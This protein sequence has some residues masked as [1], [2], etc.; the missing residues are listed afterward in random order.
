MTV[1][2][3]HWISHDSWPSWPFG[4]LPSARLYRVASL[5]TVIK[6][7]WSTAKGQLQWQGS[8]KR[9]PSTLKS[10]RGGHIIPANLETQDQAISRGQILG[11]STE[12]IGFQEAT[13]LTLNKHIS[14][15]MSCEHG[16]MPGLADG[17][18][19]QMETVTWFNYSKSLQIPCFP[20]SAPRCRQCNFGAVHL[21]FLAST[22][23]GEKHVSFEE[24]KQLIQFMYSCWSL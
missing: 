6:E 5:D 9:S 18:M 20:N 16:T 13:T 22:G 24:H 17:S 7:D 11:T 14:G 23:R 21:L 15:V 1:P 12:S 4:K 2:L 8:R 10:E 19:A 3:T